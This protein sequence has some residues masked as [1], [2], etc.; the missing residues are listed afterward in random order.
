M[1]KLR[2]ETSKDAI[3]I[4]YYN[5]THLMFAVGGLILSGRCICK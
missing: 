4:Y 3:L 5:Y 2:R 1:S